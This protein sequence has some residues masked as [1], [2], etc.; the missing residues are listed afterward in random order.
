MRNLRLLDTYTSLSVNCVKCLLSSH[1]RICATFASCP[2]E[3]ANLLHAYPT[4]TQ[5]F[6]T[7]Q[8]PL[9]QT[10][11]VIETTGPPCASKPRPIFGPKLEAAKAEFNKLQELGIV[12]PSKSP[13]SSPIH[14]VPKGTGFRVCGD[15]RRLNNVT[16]KDSYPMNNPQ[17]LT[18]LLHGTSVYSKLDLVRGYNQ[19]PMDE[20]SIG[21]TCVTTPFGSFEY[22]FMPFGLCN[23]S[24]TFQRFMNELFGHLPFVYAYIDDILVFSTSK[25]EHIDHLKQ[26]FEILYKNGL[27]ISPEKCAF[28]KS[29]VDFLGHS[30]S[31]TGIKPHPKNCETVH[32]IEP[33]TTIGE[34][35]SFLGTIGFYRRYI[36]HF[37]DTAVPLHDKLA[38]SDNSS[39]KIDLTDEEMD[40][41]V[42]LKQKL[43]DTIESSYIDPSCNIF[44]IKSD[45]SNRAIGAV[46]Y[47]V[48]NGKHNTILFFSRKL[49]P[50]EKRYSTFDRELLAAKDAVE[51]FLPY[52]D[53]QS[54]TL[55]TDHRPLVS[56]FV[57]K[58]EC[59]SDRQSRHLSFL[60][61]YVTSVE[62]IEGKANVEADFLSRSTSHVSN[63]ITTSIADL[64]AI[65]T[66]QASDDETAKYLTTNTNARQITWNNKALICDCSLGHDRPYIPL[67]LREA[68]FKQIHSIGHF[69]SK[70]SNRMISQRFFWPRMTQDIKAL[71]KSCETCQ[72]EKVN[73]HTKP[74]LKEFTNPS[75]RFATVHI[76]IV[77]LPPCK[78]E[79]TGPDTYSHILTMIDR[80]TRWIEAVPL[81]SIT[82]E[83]VASAFISTW[84]PRFGIPLEVVTD[85]GRQFESELFANLSRKLGFIRLRT[86]AYRPQC[87][88]MIERQHRTLK[89]IL[90]AYRGNWID[91]LPF[92]LFAMHISPSDP[93]QCSPFTLVTGATPLI[94]PILIDSKTI[95]N[96]DKSRF[97]QSLTSYFET[98]SF[99]P[100]EWTQP[101]KPYLPEELNTC[102]RVWVRV[103]RVKRPLESPYS[104][105]YEVVQRNTSYFI[106][107]LPSGREES[108]SLHRIK[109]F[110]EPV[111]IQKHT[112]EERKKQLHHKSKSLAEPDH[113]IE[114]HAET[115]LLDD[116][117]EDT[118]N[119]QRF[120]KKIPFQTRSGRTVRFTNKNTLHTYIR[121][122]HEFEHD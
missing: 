34:L 23:A 54:V 59:K 115:Q 36:N 103:D 47:Q 32:N 15:Y 119:V 70:C 5:P 9:H 18:C 120:I 74:P 65:A 121:P 110:H 118:S 21:K 2:S 112:P 94:P 45:A 11:H 42:E 96:T 30:I 24:Q 40:A 62:Y 101:Y 49:N 63:T 66:E 79:L 29:S 1:Q 105:P 122:D 19:I 43:Q 92:A 89:S 46:L 81:N 68:V 83:S 12:R 7:N 95:D 86:T 57:K 104:G 33:P 84:I 10:R 108:I 77:E 73:R 52:I 20:A 117:G 72:R 69:G 14:L 27:K 56:A 16:V 58:G 99:T 60:S 82:A 64:D 55:F 35:R 25:T 31:P 50:T 91:A 48:V 113:N 17:A 111:Y 98:L 6:S 107:R 3:I 114:T 75:A 80:Y 26:V 116:T 28:L 71:V 51:R 90:R 76:D 39:Y 67:S 13:W 97:T 87:N 93:Q 100:P 22:K 38:L 41:F 37:A 53:G 78:S 85:R 109:P 8:P 44:V 106:L 4:I 61:E 88:G 102:K